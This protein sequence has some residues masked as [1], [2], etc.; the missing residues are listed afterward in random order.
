MGTALAGPSLLRINPMDY[1]CN[2]TCPMC[3]LQHLPDEELG[4]RKKRDLESGMNLSDY[5]RLFGGM[6]PGLELV[7]VVGGGEPL[8]HPDAIEIMREIRR[9]GWRGTLTTNGTLLKEAAV[10]RIVEMKWNV[11]RVSV[12]AGD[13]ETYRKVH[14]ADHFGALRCNL[15]A[16]HKLRNGSSGGARDCELVVFHVLQKEN[17]GAVDGLFA[18]A[19]EA[20]AN[21]IEFD[22]I[23]PYGPGKSL[24]TG[25]LQQLRDALQVC[26]RDSHIPCNLDQI[27]AELDAEM[28]CAAEGMPFVPAKYCSAGFDQS[29]ITAQGDVLP[30]CFSSEVMGNVRDRSF[31]EIWRG[32]KYRGFRTRLINGR[33]ANY[34]IE[35]RCTLPE[36]LHH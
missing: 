35:N 33:F 19:E 30:C 24:G 10:R 34:C 20:G 12:S 25:E 14:G 8:A 29:F 27:L 17:A 5:V 11:V 7:D 32:R 9:R 3:W 1:V 26:A 18:I 2:H 23:I 21:F 4:R 36:V 16:F 22:K 15:A 28:R 13:A 31:R 6:L